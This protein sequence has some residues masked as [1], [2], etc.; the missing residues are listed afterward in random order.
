MPQPILRHGCDMSFVYFTF[1]FALHG[2]DESGR[3]NRYIRTRSIDHAQ[4]SDKVGSF[5]RDPG[6]GCLLKRPVLGQD[7]T[8]STTGIVVPAQFWAGIFQNEN[9]AACI[10]QVLF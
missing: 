10:P 9:P 1:D 5:I 2:F 3:A 8:V 4:E 7:A 6:M